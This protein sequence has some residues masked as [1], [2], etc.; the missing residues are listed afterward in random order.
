VVLLSSRSI[1]AYHASFIAA[2]NKRRLVSKKETIYLCPDSYQPVLTPAMRYQIMRPLRR[3]LLLTILTCSLT[4]TAI[5]AESA[6]ATTP[7]LL[8]EAP[9]AVSAADKKPAEAVAVQP[10]AR[11]GHVD[12]ARIAT[13]SEA[14]KAGQAELVALKGK[15][16]GQIEAKRKQLEKQQAAIEAKLK[17]L[18][19]AQRETK[20]KEFQKKVEDFQKYGMNAEKEL[21]AKQEEVSSRL[22]K[23]I[24]QASAELGKARGLALVVVKRELLY[25]A[26]GVEAQD[27]TEEVIKIIDK[28]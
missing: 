6:P 22:F 28:K 11:L 15:F 27:V 21:L 14:G 26:S 1:P 12:L 10:S 2:R 24:E 4:A 3:V 9:Q 5:A 7:T 17:T 25:L 20:G 19:P 13:A 18:T 23:A 8:T 16:Q